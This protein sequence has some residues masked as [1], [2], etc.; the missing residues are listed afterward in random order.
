[1]AKKKCQASKYSVQMWQPIEPKK[2]ETE[3][4]KVKWKLWNDNARRNANEMGMNDC[5]SMYAEL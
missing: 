2:G 1:M 4:R 3:R 5:N